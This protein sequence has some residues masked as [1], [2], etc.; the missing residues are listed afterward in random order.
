MLTENRK[1][2]VRGVLI[3]CLIIALSS[4]SYAG[5]GG[6]KHDMTIAGAAGGFSGNFGGDNDEPCVYCH[7]PHGSY[8]GAQTPLW[9]KTLSFASGFTVYSSATMDST[10]TN[11]PSTISLLCLSCHDGVG[12]INSILNTPGPGSTPLTVSGFDQIGDTG[13]DP[14]TG[15]PFFFNIGEGDPTGPAAPVNLSNDHPVSINW[16][17]KGI[18]GAGGFLATPTAPARLVSVGGVNKVEC[19]S[20]HN[21]HNGTAFELGG[22]Q[23]MLMS[24]SGSALCLACHDK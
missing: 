17:D 7:T 18:V 24:N 19:T 2:M 23:F 4:I 8:T 5:V 21:P 15:R 13:L 20:C 14:A 10:P 22:M 6:S 9:N 11:P 16:A 1:K 12:A 3:G